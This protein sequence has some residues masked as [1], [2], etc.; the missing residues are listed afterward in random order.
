MEL[1]ACRNWTHTYTNFPRN[2]D[3][4]WL[5]L[6]PNFLP[7]FVFRYLKFEPISANLGS[8]FRKIFKND[9]FIYQI[10]HKIWCHL[11]TSS[12]ILLP[13]LAARLRRGFCTKYPTGAPREVNP[14]ILAIQSILGF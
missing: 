4:Y 13:M 6:R 12:L 10:L 11:Y 14:Y 8:K 3:P 1:L 5:D 7:Y 2:S 9:P